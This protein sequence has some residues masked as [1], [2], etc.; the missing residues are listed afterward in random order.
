MEISPDVL[1]KIKEYSLRQLNINEKTKRNIY[2]DTE[3]LPAGKVLAASHQK[4]E[5]SRDTALVFEDLAPQY[6][7]GH[8]CRSVLYNPDTGEPYD[9]VDSEFPPDWKERRETLKIFH[10]PVKQVNWMKEKLK[11]PAVV[12][13]LA[14]A[15]TNALGT[16]HAILFSGDSNNRHVNDME[17]LYRTLIDVYGFNAAN[18]HVLNHDGTINYFGGPKP[19][20][21]WPGDNT[22]YRMPVN[23]S[24][25]K[26]AF[27]NVLDTLKTAMQLEDFL[28]IHM[29]NHGGHDGTES[30]L[31]AYSG[32]DYTASDFAAKLATLPKF[33]T[34]AVMMEQCHS[35]GFVSPIINST[36]A[37]ATHVAAACEELKGSIGGADFDP[38]ALDWIAGVTGSYADG[39]GLH[40]VVDGNGDGR[41][42]MSE[43]F[44]YADADKDPYDTPVSDEKPADYGNHIFLGLP[45]HDLYIRD[46]LDD[47]GQEPLPAGGISSSPDVI[48]YNQELLDPQ[49]TLGTTAAMTQANLG[50]AVEK[51][52]DNFIYLR[53]QN[54]GE[55]ACAG[56]ATVYWC[57][58]STFPTPFSWNLINTTPI[59]IPSVSPGDVKVVG[60]VVWSKDDIPATGHYCFVAL[61]NSGD[62]P[63][64]DP[65]TITNISDFY[66]FIRSNNNATWKNF[67]VVDMFANSTNSFDFH[68]QGW[69]RN[70]YASDLLIDIHELP[71]PTEVRLRILKRLTEG[72]ALD[73]LALEET[74]ALYMRYRI[75]ASYQA[76]IHDIPLKPSD[77][78][79]ATL[80]LTLP[81]E[82][83]DGAYYVSVAQSIDGREMGRVTQMIAV[84]DHP[85]VANRNSRSRELH[86]NRCIWVK[87]MAPH[88]KIAYISLDKALKHGY[89]GCAYCLPEH[90]TG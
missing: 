50:E 32:D 59:T 20:G 89:N 65:A 24:G 29:N 85:F 67:N 1:A 2:V 63:A 87:M 62:D 25:T 3:R 11:K 47:T 16:R 68:I 88:N 7:W 39:S 66:E 13:G 30:Y 83:P 75:T 26:A 44:T 37:L 14:N 58:V 17:F 72:A 31:C 64:P 22:A 78:S 56:T 80:E 70:A 41:I 33:A 12:S 23:G 48:V 46:N 9:S 38:F 52:Q 57:P 61:L 82:T 10:E 43:A 21:N 76:I 5:L 84:G 40:L 54:R 90:D 60:P 79:Q 69:P 71:Q 4:I 53:V 6:N 35:G 49:G 45:A 74:S 36:P 8:P 34:L 19:I 73:G 15:L 42:S 28:F 86:R 55:S 27:E 77:D 51:G 18:I 81:E